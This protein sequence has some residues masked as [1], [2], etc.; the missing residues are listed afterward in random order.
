MIRTTFLLTLIAVLAAGLLAYVHHLTR[1]PIAENR[2]AHANE[3][4]RDLINSL[5]GKDLCEA[6]FHVLEIQSKAY[7]GDIQVAVVYLDD[8]LLG[9][10][11][12]NHNETPGYSNIL[13]PT[14]W[15]GSFGKRPQNEIDAVT[16]ATITSKAVLRGVEDANLTFA[17]EGNPCSSS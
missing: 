13:K 2:K 17:T 15:I 7:G 3:Q 16:R 9:V 1:E 8:S 14:E 4:L 10:R 11:V 12:L 5:D 6:G